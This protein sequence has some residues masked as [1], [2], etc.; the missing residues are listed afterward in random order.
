MYSNTLEPFG[1]SQG[2]S[3]PHGTVNHFNSFSFIEQSNFLT[4]NHGYPQP[5]ENNHWLPNSYTPE[6]HHVP[7]CN[8]PTTGFENLIMPDSASLPNN[9]HIVL[10]NHRNAPIQM[11]TSA[12]VW[13][14]QNTLSMNQF[15][16]N[17]SFPYNSNPNFGIRRTTYTNMCNSKFNPPFPVFPPMECVEEKKADDENSKLLT[18]PTCG[19]QYCRKS[20]LKAHMK[21]H[22]SG[23]KPFT[24]EICGKSFSQAANLTAHRRVHTGEKPFTCKICS[25]AFSQSSSLT[26]HL[27]THTH[28]RPYRCR[29]LHCEKAFTDSSTLTKHMRTHTG[30]KPYACNLCSMRFSQSGNLHRHM[31]THKPQ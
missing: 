11:Q 23:E 27:R 19:K 15:H 29:H 20:T 31:K 9:S 4:S 17:N 10:Q 8:G 3:V 6:L 30:Q 1:F 12:Q 21:Q 16:L 14:T 26:T 24:C 18:C 2:P 5:H 13:N 7:S 22:Y 25:R 28:D